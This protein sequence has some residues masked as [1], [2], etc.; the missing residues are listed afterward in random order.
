MDA[1]R[2]ELEQKRRYRYHI[3]NDTPEAAAERICAILDA[4]AAERD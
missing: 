2:W 1:A 3:I 4:E